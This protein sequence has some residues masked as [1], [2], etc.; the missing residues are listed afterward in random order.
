[1]VVV[2]VVAALVAVVVVV[3]IKLHITAQPD[4]VMR[5]NQCYKCVCTLACVCF[6]IA[7]L[8]QNIPLHH[9]MTKFAIHKK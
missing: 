3:L 1:M 9:G 6:K 5:I 4:P 7:R 2:V 8:N